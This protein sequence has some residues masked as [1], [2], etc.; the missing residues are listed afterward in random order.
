MYAVVSGPNLNFENRIVDEKII[1]PKKEKAIII[2]G[3]KLIFII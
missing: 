2:F 1:F 3:L